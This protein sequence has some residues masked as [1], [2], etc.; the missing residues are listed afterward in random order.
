MNAQRWI[1]V[2]VLS[3]AAI[4]FVVDR[5]FLSEPENAYADE[6]LPSVTKAKAANKASSETEVPVDELDPTLDRLEQLPEAMPGRDIFSLSGAFLARRQKLEEEALKAAEAAEVPKVDPAETFAKEH[7]LQTTMVSSNL[8]MAVVDGK[9]IRIGETIDGFR[10]V[11]IN[12][13]QVKFKH[14]ADGATVVL[15]LPSQP[16]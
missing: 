14:H 6:P 10:L 1:Y 5:V 4:A 15:S 12:S 16:K 13:Y 3:L 9:V 11:Q 8:S 2:G 7:T